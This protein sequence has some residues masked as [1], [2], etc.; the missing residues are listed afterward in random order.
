M[1]NHNSTP[2]ILTRENGAAIAY[3][4]L[5]GKVPG[6]IFM[7]GFMSD[8][9]GGKALTLEALCRERGQAFLRFDYQGHGHS[10]GEFADGHI[11][12]W[13]GD[14]LA[15]LDELT[16]G[17]QILVGSSMGGWIMLLT[18][19]TRPERIAGLVGIAAAPDFTETPLPNELTPEQL[20]EIDD[21]G[22]VVIPSEYED[23]YIISK[24]LLEGS[25][26]SL[27]MTGD[28][29]VDC[30]VRLLHGMN[31]VSVP[32][33]TALD[34]QAR[35]ESDDVEVTLI[36]NGDH[37]LSEEADLERLKR[38]VESLLSG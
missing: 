37:R 24:T 26:N 7:T 28:I 31:D 38:A 35:L 1:P 25:R 5:E 12:I 15:A 6:V 30:P 34:I 23:D 16:E 29:P 9:D 19:I 18:A 21:K 4:R 36:K 22:L 10:S 13:A 11:G 8:M 3:H 27:I 20:L 33:K 17:P 14:A 2:D 32:W